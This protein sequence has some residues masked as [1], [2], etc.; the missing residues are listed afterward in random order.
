MELDKQQIIEAL[1]SVKDPETGQDIITVRMVENL[2]VK[3]ND[4]SFTIIVPSIKS[5]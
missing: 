3:G 5:Q 4:I 2:Q 1:R